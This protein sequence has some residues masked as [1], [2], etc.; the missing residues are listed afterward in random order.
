MI[1]NGVERVFRFVGKLRDM[2]I[3][4]G[5]IFYVMVSEGIDEKI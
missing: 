4:M 3:L 2:V 1:E 5:V